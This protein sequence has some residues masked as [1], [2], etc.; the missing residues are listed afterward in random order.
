M[1]NLFLS[2]KQLDELLEKKLE[3]GESYAVSRSNYKATERELPIILEAIKAQVEAKEPDLPPAKVTAKA[4]LT[5]KYLEKL[6]E[7]REFHLTSLSDHAKLEHVN[8]I[9]ETYR[10][11]SANFRANV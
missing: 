6:D 10:T 2:D 4:K 9:W 1:A 3:L 8:M 11:Q 5:K 7:L